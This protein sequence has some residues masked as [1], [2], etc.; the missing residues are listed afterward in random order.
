MFWK[1]VKK[2][3]RKGTVGR[4]VGIKDENNDIPKLNS[5]LTNIEGKIGAEI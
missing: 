2:N 3:E 1:E 5:N 4:S